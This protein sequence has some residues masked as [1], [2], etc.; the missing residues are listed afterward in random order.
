LKYLQATGE[1][2]SPQKRTSG[3]SEHESSSLFHAPKM[4]SW[5][6]IKPAKIN[7]DPDPQ[8]R[9]S[10]LPRTH[11]FIH[12]SFKSYG[13]TISCSTLMNLFWLTFLF[14]GDKTA[15]KSVNGKLNMILT[16]LPS[17]M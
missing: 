11:S 13:G 5:I 17:E 1:A 8:S 12:E 16:R 14:F 2:F 10:T 6:Q 9:S 7:A 3:T 4:P 15:V